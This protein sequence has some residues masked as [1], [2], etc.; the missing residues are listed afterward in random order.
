MSCN[1]DARSKKTYHAEIKLW[2]DVQEG[3]PTGAG[4]ALRPVKVTVCTECGNSEF[5]VSEADMQISFGRSTNRF[6]LGN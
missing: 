4:K 1:C 5:T 2:S 6:K 3:L